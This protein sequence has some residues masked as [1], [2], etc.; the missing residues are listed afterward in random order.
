VPQLNPRLAKWLAT[1]GGQR[2]W[3]P[4]GPLEYAVM[5]AL[6]SE[7]PATVRDLQPRFPTAAYTT[8]MTTLD[9][10]Y[11]KGLLTR[12]PRGQANAYRPAMSRL[13]LQTAIAGCI[14][15]SPQDC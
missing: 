1:F 7:S 15:K 12:E 3:G 14:L 6:W 11:K 9:R 2:G 13:E 4:L 8:L 10:L 5:S